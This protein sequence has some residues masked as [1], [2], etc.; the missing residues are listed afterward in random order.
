MKT[1][2][3][4]ICGLILLASAVQ[5]LETPEVLNGFT[6]YMN[7]WWDALI[8]DPLYTIHYYSHYMLYDLYCS[9]VVIPAFSKYSSTLMYQYC[10]AGV[11]Q[12][13]KKAYF[14]SY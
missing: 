9:W 12:E 10:R 3:V 1:S 11:M 6:D 13:L 8:A 4:L 14:K 5:G 2:F 7:N